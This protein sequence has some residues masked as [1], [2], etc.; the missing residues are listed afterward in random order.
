MSVHNQQRVP[1]VPL[2]SFRKR[3]HFANCCDK[4]IPHVPA[5]ME[6]HGWVPVGT[7]HTTFSCATFRYPTISN[8]PP[9]PHHSPSPP[10]CPSNKQATPIKLTHCQPLSPT[11]T[12]E[13][14]QLPAH[15]TLHHSTD[16]YSSARQASCLLCYFRHH[17]LLI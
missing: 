15:Y 3:E 11:I 1:Y 17:L 9:A 7:Q 4:S 5:E 16:N 14:V 12:V 10:T 8:N 13:S 6:R 2:L